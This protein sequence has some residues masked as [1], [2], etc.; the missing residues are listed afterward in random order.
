[1]TK[2][3]SMNRSAA[4]VSAMA[5]G[6]ALA[7]MTDDARG[8]FSGTVVT[9]E[10]TSSTLGTGSFDLMTSDLTPGSSI[11]DLDS[12][13][14][15]DF[16]SWNNTNNPIQITNTGGDVLAVLGDAS[17]SLVERTVGTT[18]QSSVGGA[19]ALTAVTGDINVNITTSF[20]N[21][22]AG[23]PSPRGLATG[24]L[25]LTDSFGSPDG[26]ELEANQADGSV[27][28]ALFNNGSELFAGLG[29]TISLPAGGANSGVI[30][31]D[32]PAG[33]GDTPFGQGVANINMDINFNLSD[34]DQASGTFSY[35]VPSPGTAG[36]LMLGV[37]GGLIS[38]RRR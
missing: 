15:F 22:G 24:G 17:L 26:A 6:L 5:G 37:S 30:A 16:V 14:D 27:Y 2:I 35:I 7:G 36:L 38:R 33:G 11:I 12:D 23:I 31:E 29:D 19:F 28:N 34:G 32:F 21:F 25:T 10:V 3:K 13:G 8:D 18:N 4:I 9:Y 20:V 1:M